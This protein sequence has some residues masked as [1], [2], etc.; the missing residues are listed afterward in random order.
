MRLSENKP[1][2]FEDIISQVKTNE[3]IPEDNKEQIIHTLSDYKRIIIGMAEK[4]AN[5]DNRKTFAIKDIKY[6]IEDMFQDLLPIIEL[7]D[8]KEVIDEGRN[9][10]KTQTDLS[11]WAKSVFISCLCELDPPEPLIIEKY[12][13]DIIDQQNNEGYWYSAWGSANIYDTSFAVVA[14]IEAGISPESDIIKKAVNLFKE[15]MHPYGG[16]HSSIDRKYIDVGATSWAIISL[17]KAGENPKSDFIMKPVKWLEDNQRDDGGW[18]W[19]WKGGLE[20][21]SLIP[22]TYD[23]LTALSM[24][25]EKSE[26]EVISSIIQNAKAWLINQQ[27]LVNNEEKVWGWGWEGFKGKDIDFISEVEN[28]ATAIMTL[29]DNGEGP[30]S[31]VIQTGIRWLMETR[32]GS[33][34]WGNNDTARVIRCLNKYYTKCLSETTNN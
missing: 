25:A 34:L 5:F 18:G 20:K 23:A 33:Q 21:T 19:G 9:W 7:E 1:L 27:V 30:K 15:T 16:W 24:V 8:I 32:S 13:T 3:N 4:K 17:L 26:N 6:A 28:T 14:L 22:K 12:A 31:A 11:I 2:T 10:L 29:L